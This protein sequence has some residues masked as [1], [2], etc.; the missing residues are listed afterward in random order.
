MVQ[1]GVSSGPEIFE[2]ASAIAD[3]IISRVGKRIVLALPLGLGKPNHM[4]NALV[5]RAIADPS[6]SLQIFTALR[7]KCRACR[8]NSNAVSWD[9]Y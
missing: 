3:A 9:R 1:R 6:I 4:V 5:E 7:S 8:A 2:D